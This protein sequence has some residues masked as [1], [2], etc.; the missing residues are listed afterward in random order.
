MS[1]L[2]MGR[3]GGLQWVAVPGKKRV[4]PFD[5]IWLIEL[6]RIVPIEFWKVK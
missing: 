1:F 3:R 4:N 2:S 6:T 5:E